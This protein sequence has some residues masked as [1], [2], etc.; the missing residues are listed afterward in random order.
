MFDNQTKYLDYAATIRIVIGILFLSILIVDSTLIYKNHKVSGIETQLMNSVQSQTGTL[1]TLCDEVEQAAEDTLYEVVEFSPLI[2]DFTANTV[3]L[4]DIGSRLEYRKSTAI[5]ELKQGLEMSQKE[6]LSLVDVVQNKR[7]EAFINKALIKSRL[8]KL[9]DKYRSSLNQ[10]QTASIQNS[11]SFHDLTFAVLIGSIGLMILLAAGVHFLLFL[12]VTSVN[13]DLTEKINIDLDTKQTHEEKIKIVA[14][15]EAKTQSLLKVKSAQV[16]KLQESLEL[17][18][19][20]SNKTQQ[21]KNLIYFN[22]ANDLSEY[23]KVMVLQQKIIENQTPLDR[24]E[25]WI[26]LT[27]TITQL[28][29]MA[30]N[31]FN[32]AKNGQNLHQH[33]EVY[34]TQL[35]S[36]ILV[37]MKL[38]N[39]VVFEQLSDMPTIHTDINLLKRVLKPYFKLMAQ[40]SKNIT[41]N[42]LAKVDST[43]CEIKFLGLQPAFKKQLTLL[44]EKDL[45]DFSFEEFK[46]HMANKAIVE[47]GGKYWMQEDVGEKNVFTIYWPL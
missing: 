24:N 29:S 30:G 33:G 46:V 41:I 36:E 12:P 4:L 2:N 35:M 39:N 43:F 21:D 14:D 45:V 18:I 6:L 10:I 38:T 47:R 25:N 26:T 40:N 23:I 34:L 16:L 13:K 37:S 11:S 31:Y 3:V 44:D 27:N 17:A 7:I 32:Q 20:Y 19:A 28:N 8:N 22:V 1:N 5:D 42:Y 15:K 9:S